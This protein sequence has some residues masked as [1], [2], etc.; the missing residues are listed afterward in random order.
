MNKLAKIL[1]TLP[2]EDLQ[3]IQKDLDAGHIHAI[4]NKRIIQAKKSKLALCPVCHTPIKE[5][6]GLHLQFGPQ[7]LR[8]KAT[9]DG[10][11]CLRYFLENHLG[12]K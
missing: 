10:A 1:E 6:E 3:L 4:L 11:D 5:G 7:T 2:L 9:F 8:K 12:K